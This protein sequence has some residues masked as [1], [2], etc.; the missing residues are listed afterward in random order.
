MHITEILRSWPI[1]RNVGLVS[2]MIMVTHSV[3]KSPKNVSAK[4]W[5]ECQRQRW[6]DWTYVSLQKWTKWHCQITLRSFIFQS[7]DLNVTD[8]VGLTAVVFAWKKWTQYHCQITVK[9]W[10]ECQRHDGWTAFMFTCKMNT[11]MLSNHL[12]NAKN[13]RCSL[14][15]QMSQNETILAIQSNFWQCRV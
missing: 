15:S 8:N 13:K 1:K 7:I 3:G 12:W 9:H 5:I 6:K 11:F 14:R 10:F 4:Y 2:L